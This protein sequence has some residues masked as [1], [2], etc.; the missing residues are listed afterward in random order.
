MKENEK[1]GI[2]ILVIV[3][4]V[5]I[6]VLVMVLKPGKNNNVGGQNP[7]QGQAIGGQN[8]G[9]QVGEFTK[10]NEKGEK[11]NTSEKINQTKETSD[12][13]ISNVSLKEVN[14]KT[15]LTARVTNKS[16][17]DQDGFFGNLVLLDKNNQEIGRIPAS[18]TETK[19][20][21]TIEIEASITESYAGNAYDY[22]LD[23]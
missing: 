4:I 3:A 10:I 20:D 8:N 15:T 5:I 2:L 12:F 6:L 18:I 16:G 21:E 23:R 19:P 17:K 7:N 22:R 14:G 9:Q 1:K 11:I 13:T